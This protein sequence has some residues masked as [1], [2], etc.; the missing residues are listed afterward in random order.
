MRLPRGYPQGYPQEDLPTEPDK[1]RDQAEPKPEGQSSKA[2]ESRERS[3]RFLAP[4]LK[5]R[6]SDH[7]LGG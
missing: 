5:T 1:P 2:K 4:L 6:V 3:R 7:D